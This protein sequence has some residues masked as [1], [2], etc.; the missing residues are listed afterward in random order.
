MCFIH[1]SR[2]NTKRKNIRLLKTPSTTH[3]PGNFWLASISDLIVFILQNRTEGSPITL[4]V[5]FNKLKLDKVIPPGFPSGSA[6]KNPPA[7]GGNLNSILGSGRPPREANSNP[8]QYFCLGNP[9]NRGTWWASV[10]RITKESD[11]T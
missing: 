1:P 9:V 8:L 11:T 6:L 7:N 10:R 3:F 2:V 5:L 4:W